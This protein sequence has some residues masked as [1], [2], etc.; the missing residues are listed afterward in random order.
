MIESG[1]QQVDSNSNSSSER[2]TIEAN[3]VGTAG[4]RKIKQAKSSYFANQVNFEFESE[5][6][7]SLFL[8]VQDVLKKMIEYQ[9]RKFLLKEE[10]QR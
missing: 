7:V 1:L 10:N 6:E 9:E 4:V 5:Q 3:S 8:Q 2:E